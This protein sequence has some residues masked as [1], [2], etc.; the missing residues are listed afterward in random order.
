M[1][2][3]KIS[4]KVALVLLVALA[5]I[6]RFYRLSDLPPGFYFDQAFNAFD[7]LRLL[8]GHFAI[9]FPANT[10]EEPLFFYLLMVAVALFGPTAI[11]LKITSVVVS[12]ATI[13]LIYG[14][15]RYLFRSTRIALLTTLLTVVSFWHIYYSRLGLRI[16]LELAFTLTT[17]WYFWR[18]LNHRRRRDYLMAGFSLALALYTYPTARLIPLALIILT[19]W[20]AWQDRARFRQYVGGLVLC[21][22]LSA[23]LLLPLEIY[24]ILNPDQF[25]SHVF[26]V[27]VASPDAPQ[28]SLGGYV[29]GNAIKVARMW[30]VE[31][32]RSAIRNLPG[33]PI[34]DVFAAALFAVGLVVVTVVLLRRRSSPFERSR[35]FFLLVWIGVSLVATLLS[36]EAPNF[37]RA[38]PALPA[39]LL[40]PALAI[41]V[42]YRQSP[43][44]LRA[45]GA[46]VFAA[47]LLAS[48]FLNLRDYFVSFPAFPGLYYAFEEDKIELAD[49]INR[50]AAEN[51]IYL[52]PLWYHHGTISL[53]TRNTPLKSFDSR[54]TIVLPSGSDGKDALFLFPLEQ[55]KRVETMAERLGR[56]GTRSDLIGANGAPLVLVYRIPASQLP[57][58]EDPL[59]S[60]A[61][62]GSYAR[63]SQLVNRS[64]EHQIELLGY[65]IEPAG[66]GRKPAVILFLRA[67]QPLQNNYSFSIKARDARHRVWGQEDKYPGDN[68]YPTSHWDSGEIVI[69]RFY[70]GLEPCAPGGD[71]GL[72]VEAYDPSSQEVLAVDG[73]TDKAISLGSSHA[74]ESGGNRMDDLSPTAPVDLA[75]GPQLRLFGMDPAPRELRAGEPFSLTLYWAGVG[76]GQQ[77]GSIRVHLRDSAGADFALADRDLMLPAAGRGLCTLFDVKSPDRLA[78]GAATLLVNATAIDSITVSR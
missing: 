32:D 35:A 42:L 13:P 74:E 8:N 58:R 62:T 49:W 5:A 14:F 69:E 55:E 56:T 41:D 47:M 17:Y 51:H 25:F 71:Y 65:T 67:L 29:L 31:G 78:P 11:A 24:F 37:L 61:R 2:S 52:A 48:A 53:L 68:S 39:V 7:V 34:F 77:H 57:S 4:P 26:Q 3:V 20:F 75:V 73:E 10:G 16:I 28:S 15:S 6:L 18:A 63:P 38:F 40:L 46:T 12:L 19:A 54:D 72:T 66:Q 44:R 21:G 45:V 64:W 9:F 1:H 50:K 22:L 30:F 76:N 70:P 27:S 33:R 36:D 43:P 23:V 60:L 59:A